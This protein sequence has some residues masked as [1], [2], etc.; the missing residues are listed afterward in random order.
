MSP[1]SNWCRSALIP[2]GSAGSLQKSETDVV[3]LDFGIWQ[4]FV[5]AAREAGY[6]GKFLAIAEKIDPSAC[7]RAL[8]QRVSGVFLASDSAPSLVQALH[9]V[10]R[11]GAGQIRM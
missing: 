5:A 7:A 2:R 9:V 11:G 3:L 6:Q 10:V 1:I 4:E 8:R